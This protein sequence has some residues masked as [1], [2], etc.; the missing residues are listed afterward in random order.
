MRYGYLLKVGINEYPNGEISSVGTDK[1]IETK[2]EAEQ[3]RESMGY[4]SSELDKLE[5]E[6]K[7]LENIEKCEDIKDKIAAKKKK[8][9]FRPLNKF[10]NMFK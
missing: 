1:P 8:L 4:P 6:L 9:K 5:E 3:W 2:E 7:E 10:I